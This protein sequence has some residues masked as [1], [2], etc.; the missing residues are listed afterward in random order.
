[1]FMMGR[2]IKFIGLVALQAYALIIRSKLDT[3]GVMAVTAGYPGMI[4]LALQKRS[5]DINFL[6]NLTVRTIQTTTSQ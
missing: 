6:P 4:H 1:M 5:I 3:M 2:H